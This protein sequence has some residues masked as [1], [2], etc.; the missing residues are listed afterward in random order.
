MRKRLGSGRKRRNRSPRRHDAARPIS[1]LRFLA[2]LVV[3]VALIFVFSHLTALHKL[4][5][6]VTDVRMRLNDPPEPS[7]VAVV[8]IEDEDYRTLFARCS[9]ASSQASPRSGRRSSG[10]T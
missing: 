9:N 6:F 8:R 7:A 4:Q 5:T 1:A 3:T 2:G 10:L